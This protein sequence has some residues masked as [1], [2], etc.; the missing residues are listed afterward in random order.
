MPLFR[1]E[2]AA[3]QAPRSGRRKAESSEFLLGLSHASADTRHVANLLET[4]A[5]ELERPRTLTAQVVSH[6]SGT[7]GVGRE[8]VGP[9]LTGELPKLEDYEIDLALSSL[10]TPTLPEQAI[11][12]ELLGRESVAPAQWPALVQQL[13]ARPTR[14]QFVSEDGAVHRVPLRD[15]TIERFVHRLR[16]DA[17]IPE[18]LFDLINHLPPAADRPLL[19]AIA[20][21]AVWENESRCEIL[22]R[23]LTASTG[24]DDY[25]L[26][27]VLELLKLAETYQ[28]ANVSDLLA[29]IPHWQQVLRSE[30]SV[31]GNPKRF[32]NERVQEM[33][34][35]GRDQRRNDDS[36]ILA[37]ENEQAFLE[38]LL[39]VLGG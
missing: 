19:K 30:I 7:Y 9:F 37:K 12:A 10:F 1:K 15:V 11:F 38:R 24:R 6:L 14:A 23:F 29:R 13:V 5:A 31:A 3:R 17:T 33:H 35:G 36:R 18:S 34:G 20:R 25:L 28:P 26:A 39:Q 21:R 8:A 4:L 27:D 2:I 32:F 22:I 16:L